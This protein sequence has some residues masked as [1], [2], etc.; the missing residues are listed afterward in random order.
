MPSGLECEYGGGTLQGC[1]TIAT[2][3]SEAWTLKAPTLTDCGTHAAACPT[4]YADVPMGASC[5]SSGLVWATSPP[6][7]LPRR[8]HERRRPDPARRTVRSRRA[9]S[10]KHPGFACA[11]HRPPLGSACAMGEHDLRLRLVQRGGRHGRQ[12]QERRLAAGVRR[13]SALKRSGTVLLARAA[14]SGVVGGGR[15]RGSSGPVAGPRRRGDRPVAALGAKR[16]PRPRHLSLVV[17][18]G[19]AEYGPFLAEGAARSARLRRR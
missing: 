4:T 12:L 2:C 14:A 7:L 16:L 10:A 5:T 19:Q 18:Q 3:S 17:G 11:S 13:V 8:V 15:P 1:D 9:S 6:K